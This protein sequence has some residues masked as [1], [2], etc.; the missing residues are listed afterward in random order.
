VLRRV[1]TVEVDPEAAGEYCRLVEQELAPLV[2]EAGATFEG[3]WRGVDG[4]SATVS[5]QSVFSCS[6][7]ATWNV[8][9][10]N[11]VLDPRW[12]ACAERLHPLGRGGTRRIYRSGDE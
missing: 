4:T 10:R 5:V 12:Y 11:L 7:L 9:R 1:D 3:C 6:D 2:V 8:I